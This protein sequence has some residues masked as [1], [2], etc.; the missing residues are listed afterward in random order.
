MFTPDIV[1][2]IVDRR[3]ELGLSQRELAQRCNM[4]QST[5]ARI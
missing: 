5:I 1:D 4:P 2:M 3:K